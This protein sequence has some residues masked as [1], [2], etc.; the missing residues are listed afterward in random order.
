MPNMEDLRFELDSVTKQHT[1]VTLILSGRFSF[2][3][4]YCA[5][6]TD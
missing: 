4:L 5:H 6:L 1:D 3:T 2:V